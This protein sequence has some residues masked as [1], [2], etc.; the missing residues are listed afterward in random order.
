MNKKIKISGAIEGF[1]QARTRRDTTSRLY[2]YALSLFER[3]LNAKC[4]IIGEVTDADISSFCRYLEN[5]YAPNS[6]CII[7]GIVKSLFLFCE[8]HDFIDKNPCSL[9]DEK[10]Y[11]CKHKHH[12]ALTRM[13]FD[14]CEKAF[15]ENNIG[16]FPSLEIHIAALPTSAI[17]IAHFS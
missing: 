1:M 7:Y 8:R 2:R 12:Q 14:A 16:L 5:T 13:Q 6:A 10:R 11:F 15:W 17:C 9:I 4:D 3:H